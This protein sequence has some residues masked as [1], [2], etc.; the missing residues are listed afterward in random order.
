M[1]AK[2]STEAEL[3]GIYEA[4]PQVLLTCYFFEEQGYP[5]KQYYTSRQSKWYHFGAKQEVIQ[6][7]TH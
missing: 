6:F 7:K 1:N 3:I 4:L 5:I 2:S